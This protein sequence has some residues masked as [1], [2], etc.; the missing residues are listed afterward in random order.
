MDH[1]V[2]SADRRMLGGLHVAA[3]SILRSYASDRDVSFHLFSEDL[4]DT[5]I[6]LLKQTLAHAGRDYQ[7]TLESVDGSLFAGFPTLQ[8]SLAT[9][10]RLV[11]PL[12]LDVDRFLYCDVDTLC[13]VDLSPLLGL[14]L[15]GCPIALTPEAPIHGSPDPDVAMELGEEASG[16]YYNAGVM[17][18]DAEQW[19]SEGL[20][21][22]CLEYI[23]ERQP[24]WHDQSAL[25]F[26]LHGRILK[27]PSE[28]NCRTNVRKA[29]ADLLSSKNGYGYLLH[30]VDFPKPW[31]PF[32]CWVHPWGKLW[33]QYYRATQH[34]RE[35]IAL[36]EGNCLRVLIGNRKGY[37]KIFKD[38]V[39]FSL[40]RTGLVRRV[41]GMEQAATSST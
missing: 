16:F 17:V 12:V 10:F 20:T 24:N 2:F 31:S 23:A 28:Y 18:V 33:G 1:I 40:L 26:V 39:L 14:D 30:F 32:G 13:Q 29:W 27:L 5:D 25:N 7:L 38:R 3:L 9:Y 35:N 22:R 19:R 6:D 41:K 34:Y 4:D 15:S 8:D 21:N 37:Q 11:A 36:N